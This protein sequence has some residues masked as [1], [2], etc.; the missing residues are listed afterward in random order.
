MSDELM[1]CPHCSWH[2]WDNDDAYAQHL[3]REHKLT[4]PHRARFADGLRKVMGDIG[5]R[6]HWTL[7]PNGGH[8]LSIT[9]PG[10]EIS[11]ELL[12]RISVALGTTLMDIGHK[13]GR[14]YSEV[15]PEL[16][17]GDVIL[18]VRWF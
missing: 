4:L 5:Y 11:Y 10:D 1:H 3:L 6:A 7:G 12:A 8:R 18:S 15:T 13:A 17:P 16:G 9:V 2:A 14:P